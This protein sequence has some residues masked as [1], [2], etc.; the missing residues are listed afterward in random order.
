[1][2]LSEHE[3]Q[4]IKKSFLNV[5]EHGRLYLFGSRVDDFKKGG[6]IDLYIEPTQKK[7][8]LSKK[9][10]FLVQLK[11]YIGEQKIDV[12]IDRGENRLI[13]TIAKEKGVLL[14]QN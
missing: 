12:V 11:S 5:F 2:R 1:M 10:D 6:D 9:I 8:L 14:C 4:S 3:L 7:K 13:D